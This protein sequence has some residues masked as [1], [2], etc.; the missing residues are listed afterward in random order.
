MLKNKA[1]SILAT[2]CIMETAQIL[3]QSPWTLTEAATTGL[4]LLWLI[5][6]FV[7]ELEEP[8]RRKMFD[9][10]VVAEM[11]MKIMGETGKSIETVWDGWVHEIVKEGHTLEKV[12]EFIKKK[13]R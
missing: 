3:F 4:F 13:K 9:R 12:K 5:Y 2:I 6:Y 8:G 11:V 1:I 10:K 7:Q